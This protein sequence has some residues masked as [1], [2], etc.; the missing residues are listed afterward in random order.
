MRAGLQGFV[1]RQQKAPISACLGH[2]ALLVIDRDRHRGPRGRLAGNDR[3][4]LAVEIGGQQGDT[5][6]V[7][8]EG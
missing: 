1:E 5:G 6:A 7:G 3:P 4:A 2:T 8:D